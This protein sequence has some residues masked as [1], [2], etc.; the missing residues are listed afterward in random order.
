[1]ATQLD[2]QLI[3]AVDAI[4]RGPTSYRDDTPAPA[5][6]PT[7]PVPQPDKRIVPA[8][9][10]GI[11]VASIGIGAGATGIG[12]A[13]W[14]AMKGL[15]MATL[16]GVLVIAAPFAGVAIVAITI[17][18]LLRCLRGVHTETHHHYNAP[19]DQRTQQSK[20]TGLWARTNNEQ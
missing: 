11:A 1:M 20:T 18:G 9:A 7:P 5:Y 13:V 6:G 3:A 16:N 10:S 14:L 12:C 15:S 19:V 8:W 2:P 4:Y 17:G